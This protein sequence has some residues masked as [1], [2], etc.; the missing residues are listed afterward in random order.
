LTA[1]PHTFGNQAAFI[2]GHRPADLDQQLIMRIATHGLINEF[3]LASASF[4]FF[5]KQHLVDIVTSQAIRG[6]HQHAVKGSIAYL[7]AQAIQPWATQ[8]RSAVAIIAK[9][10]LLIPFPSLF[11]TVF[12]QQM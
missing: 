9:N 5:H 7:I 2:L 10:V 8:A 11:L 6:C 12:T 3:D 1:S 4:K